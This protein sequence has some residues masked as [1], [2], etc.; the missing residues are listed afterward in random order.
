[1]MYFN[2]F[3]SMADQVKKGIIACGEDEHLQ[4]LQAKVPI[5]Y[6]GFSAT[7]DFQANNI[8]ETDK[9]TEFDVFVRNTYFDTFN[10][11]LYGNHHV[12]NALSSY[13]ILSL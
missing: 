11:P 7:N 10:I 5:I 9:G 12:L 6:Y 2:A 13:R 8:R 4:H 1:M 3:Q